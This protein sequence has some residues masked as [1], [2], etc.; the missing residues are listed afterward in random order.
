MMRVTPW[1]LMILQ[2]S[3]RTLIDGL[4]FIVSSRSL[5][6]VR[7][8]ALP[9]AAFLFERRLRRRNPSWGEASEGAVTSAPFEFI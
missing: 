2:C 8:A 6:A 9:A 5:L 3:H 1:R 7:A 4:T